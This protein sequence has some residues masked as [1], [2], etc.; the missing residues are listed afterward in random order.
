MKVQREFIHNLKELPPDELLAPGSP[1]CAGC[2][3]LAA[4]RLV[5]KVLDGNV[6]VVNAAGC[7]TLL[8]AYPYT[9]LRC[10]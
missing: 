4:L 2:G 1:L 8:A 7:L 3:G 6:V 9:P 10:S 5:L